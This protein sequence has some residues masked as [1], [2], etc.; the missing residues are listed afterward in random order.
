MSNKIKPMKLI[1][2]NY[3]FTN[4]KK[5]FVKFPMT[6]I[7]ATIGVIIAIYLVEN[8]NL[9][10]AFPYINLMLSLALGIP[11]FISASILAQKNEFNLKQ[12]LF[13]NLFVLAILILIYFSLPDKDSTHNTSLPYIRYTFY[14]IIAHLLVSFI[15]FLQNK[16]LN[17]FWN[18]NKTL[19]IRLVTSLIYSGFL[20]L[21]LVIA[22][23]SMQELFDIKLHNELFAEFWIVIIG[24][25]NIWFFVTVIPQNVDELDEIQEYPKG[26]K[27]FSQ[28]I[29]FPLL[30]LYLVILYAYGS[31]ILILSSWPKGIVSYLIIGM[32][33][34]G[35]F[36]FLLMHPYSKT[37]ENVWM[38]K[39]TKLFYF[40]LIPLL[41]I[42]FI[43]ISMRIGDYGITI[44][45][46]LIFTI[47]IWLT[48]VSIYTILGKTNIKFIP[49]SLASIL[50]LISFGPWG[51]FSISERM[52]VN[53]LKHILEEAQ[54]LKNGKIQNEIIWKKDSL[55]DLFTNQKYLNETK[56][57]DSLH[58]EVYSIINYLDNHHGFSSIRA[59]FKQD[60]DSII[61]LSNNGRER[62]DQKN[63]ADVFMQSM[64]LKYEMNYSF[65]DTKTVSYHSIKSNVTK[66][67]GYEYFVKFD[68]YRNEHNMEICS[69]IIDTTDFDLKFSSKQK[70]ELELQ[71]QNQS[72][73][74]ELNTLI[75]QLQKEYS[76][77]GEA[78]IP[79]NKMQIL[80]NT[81]DFD[82]KFEIQDMIIKI[83]QDKL[84]LYTI[85]GNILIKVKNKK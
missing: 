1:S 41:V 13:S 60:I 10:N 34:V 84:E 67:I 61:S 78:E 75:N 16:Q 22:L 58:N 43:A 44:N 38:K 64:G 46:Y 6:I 56:L 15:P 37:S 85:S 48:I 59:W 12:K 27:I 3:L 32:S 30:I 72:I 17:G 33:V 45:R 63:E 55:P 8:P 50:F 35:I 28:Y 80:T 31:K 47:G 26:L 25:F 24:L 51:V 7:S 49:I 62:F 70:N 69:F 68:S 73:I 57:T 36:T 20:Y 66:T 11:L 2:I 81:K 79:E 74:I 77:N 14:N 54:I 19:F 5:S 4:A 53:R 42:L 71:F 83:E 21:G 39:A 40:V 23:L 76:K 9:K 65:D 18:Y 52:Q 82:F 29:L